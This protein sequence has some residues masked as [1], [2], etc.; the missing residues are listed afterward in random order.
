MI[1]KDNIWNIYKNYDAICCTCNNVIK[2]NGELVMGAGIAKEFKIKYDWLSK[3]WGDRIK[4]D[5]N[6]FITLMKVKPHL[7]YFQ[8]KF[9]WKDKSDIDLIISSMKKLCFQI[10]ILNWNKVLLPQPGCTNG[11]LSW[12]NEVYPKIK[13]MLDLYPIDIIRKG[14]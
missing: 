11:G 2:N 1:I 6:F 12:E 9:H 5:L 10:D 3:S 8:T 7:I 13:H 4:P 14:E